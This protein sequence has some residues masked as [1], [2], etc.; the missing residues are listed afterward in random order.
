VA[1]V[2]GDQA[3]GFLLVVVVVV[4]PVLDRPV[5]HVPHHEAGFAA[6]GELPVE[7]G[8]TVVEALGGDEQEAVELIELE[9]L[10]V[11]VAG[12]LL[13]AAARQIHEGDALVHVL[14]RIVGGLHHAHRRDLLTGDGV[15]QRRLAAARG[16]DQA[17]AHLDFLELPDRLLA[18]LGE[19]ADE[20]GVRAGHGAGG[21][22]SLPNPSIRVGSGRFTAS[23][24]TMGPPARRPP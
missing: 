8:V 9:T 6:G 10:D 7:V 24:G 1:D 17:A 11:G 2:G 4:Q 18:A 21:S 16:A 19:F 20:V 22:D 3:A 14:L 23:H 12:P 5:D 15:D 13:G